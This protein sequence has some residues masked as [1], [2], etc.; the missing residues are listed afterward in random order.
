[1][2]YAW[3]GFLAPIKNPPAFN[4]VRPGKTVTLGFRLGGDYGLDVIAAAQVRQ[5]NCKS[6]A[7]LG[8]FAPAAGSLAFNSAAAQYAYAW[9]ASKSWKGTCRELML[10]LDDGTAHNARIK[11]R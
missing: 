3:R 9:L 10:S 5:V 8:D 6:G 1:V 4:K 7:P 11:I 2:I